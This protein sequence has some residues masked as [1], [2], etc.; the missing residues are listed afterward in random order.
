MERKGGN[1]RRLLAFK[2]KKGGIK[3][4]RRKSRGGSFGQKDLRR[5]S[6]ASNSKA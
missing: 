2:E 1:L 5:A 4:N 6:V 3:P